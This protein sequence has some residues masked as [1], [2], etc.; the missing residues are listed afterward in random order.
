MNLIL[1]I[2]QKLFVDKKKKEN[3]DSQ[4]NTLQQNAENKERQLKKLRMSAHKKIN[5]EVK[6]IAKP[7]VYNLAKQNVLAVSK[8]I[9][10]PTL[11]L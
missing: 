10:P 3:L 4:F 1:E 11:T 6:D 9:V 8:E 2:L 7:I 5:M